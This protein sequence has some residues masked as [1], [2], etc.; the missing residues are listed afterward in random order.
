MPP[1]NGN[2]L[3]WPGAF[4]AGAIAAGGIWAYAGSFR[5]AFVFDDLATIRDNP[6]IRHLWPW[7]ESLLPH[8]A[9]SSASGR[10]VA[11]FTFALNYGLSGNAV[12]SYHAL[13]L[14][15]H[16]AAG[17]VLF[18]IVRR[19]L[20]PDRALPVAF[21]TALLWTLHP[22]QTEAVTYLVQ[23]TES[24]MG[25]LYLLTLYGFIRYSE[26]GARLPPDRGSALRPD[27]PREPGRTGAHRGWAWLSVAS[28]ALGMGTK[29][30]MVTAPLAVFLYDRTFVT[31]SA[32]RSW[33]ERRS[34]YLVL[35]AT[36][37]VLAV[38]VAS[39]GGTRGGTAGF[40]AGATPFTYGLTQVAAIV[41]YLRL[42][43]WPHRLVFDYGAGLISDPRAVVFP[44][45][46]IAILLIVTVLGL[47]RRSGWGYLGAWFFLTLAPTSSIVPVATQTMAEHRLYLAL[48]APAAAA[49]LG[50]YAL[51]G[52]RSPMAALTLACL[53]GWATARR[54]ALY[55]S[56]Q[57]LWADTAAAYPV[58][59]RAHTNL[60]T[61]LLKNGQVPEAIAQFQTALRIY[62]SDPVT[63]LDLGNALMQLDRG[64][65][66]MAQFRAALQVEPRLAP[67]HLSLGQA[68]ALA[69]RLPEA[70]VELE[71]GLSLQPAD[72]PTQN[73][74][75]NL[76]LRSGRSEEAIV[77]YRAALRLDPGYLEARNNLG[78]ALTS[79]GKFAEAVEELTA[80]LR[81]DPSV[82]EVHYNLGN[83]LRQ[84]GRKAEAIAEFQAALRLKPEYPKARRALERAES[85]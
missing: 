56:P 75:G 38:L 31:G 17:L 24:L 48:A 9:Q 33:R 77:H 84:A 76:L 59:D 45:L 55:A 65:E 28:C 21:A 60:G 79:T 58:N 78:I 35:T 70:I 23:R 53:L 41:Y 73:G 80:A 42:C 32:A 36:W 25:L 18:G 69:G 51:L 27:H 13:N 19:T 67:A 68:L 37:L 82:P 50:L 44:G 57:A 14:L 49:A 40:H 72:A 1:P 46:L 34:F 66:A 39:T 10:P 81:A 63:H 61:I 47:I 22:L 20:K 16:V 4:A 85:E 43:L 54:N 3:G 52:R 26:G 64:E 7:W 15:I 29:E 2:R 12:W 8:N 11:N 5:G 74:V 62:P 71:A 30:V 83:A 6:G